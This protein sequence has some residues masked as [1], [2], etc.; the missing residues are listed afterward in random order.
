M[1]NFFDVIIEYI[2]LIFEWITNIINS[3]LILL[4]LM[5]DV[6]ATPIAFSGFLW[7]PLGACAL[8]ITAIAVLKLILGR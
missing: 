4:G 8:S 5:Y 3:F 7:A 2:S 1:L 6:F